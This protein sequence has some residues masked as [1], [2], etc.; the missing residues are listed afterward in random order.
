[1]K[2]F[3]LIVKWV[4]TV[5]LI[6]LAGCQPEEIKVNTSPLFPVPGAFVVAGTNTNTGEPVSK[7]MK[8]NESGI[9]VN[10]V[11]TVK[12]SKP[13]DPG[14]VSVDFSDDAGSQVDFS[15]TI[16]GTSLIIDPVADLAFATKYNVS[17]DK[18]IKAEDGGLLIGDLTRA[19]T[20]ESLAPTVYDGQIFYM[21]FNVDFKEAESGTNATVVGSPGVATEGILGGAY[22]GA[23]DS[24]L[25][26]PTAGLKS[27]MI[28]VSFWLKVNAVPDRAGILVVSPPDPV[29]PDK[30]NNHTHG[31]RFFREADSGNQRFKLNLGDGT[32]E[33]W[34]DPG[35][36]G[37]VDPTGNPWVHFAFT[38]SDTEAVL[39][40]N[41]EI[42]KQTAFSGISWTDCNI[43][44]I[45][46]GAP[47]FTGWDHLSDASYMDELRMFNRV[48]TQDA[49]KAIIDEEKYNGQTLYMP[50]DGT[51]KDLAT[52]ADATVVGAPGFAGESVTGGDSYAGAADSYLTFPTTGL[53]GDEFSAAF[54]LKVNAVPDRAG[55]LAASP[56]DPDNP[57]K[58]NN[59]TH[60]F[61]FFREA[62]ATN[63][64]FKLNIGNG[65]S[66]NWVDPGSAGDIDPS[67]DEWVHF[68][69]TISQT[70]AVLYLNGQVIKQETLPGFSWTDCEILSIMSGAP[71]F[72]GWDHFSDLSY[73]DELHLFN[74]AITPGQVQ[75]I[76]SGE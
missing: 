22:E 41:G 19:F 8:Q 75:A 6:V 30:P 39:Y 14:T 34:V 50:F 13:V 5:S 2:I 42:I 40:M 24:Y 62:D 65:T 63:Q 46:S 33:T 26:F 29:A 15:M 31:F 61:R 48:L 49:I 54:W 3:S 51:Y 66:E 16:E 59:H 11:I 53:Q 74:K 23:A 10:A 69:F 38:L 9:P 73:M 60:G 76:M 55:I 25:T 52:N 17:I 1:M 57:D 4:L 56:P 18:G 36:A 64:R 67:A 47:L 45:M 72:I 44:S 70:Q 43:L 71:R 7:E 20:T 35:P 28:S 37:D 68:A 21:P 12:F 27:D 32:A 58:P